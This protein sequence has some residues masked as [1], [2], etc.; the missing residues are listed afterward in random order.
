M[1]LREPG[2]PSARSRSSRSRDT[3]NRLAAIVS[4][5]S[6]AIIS[7]TLD[8]TVTSWNKGAEELF[9][10]RQEEMIGQ[11]IRCIIPQDRQ[12]EEEKIIEQIA[13]GERV[14]EY[15]TVRLHKHGRL[16]EVSISVSPIRGDKGS[17]IGAPKLRGR[18]RPRNRARH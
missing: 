4:S 18:S 6:D 2:S 1:R 8:G 17:I 14:E 7:K 15:G 11:S 16:I 9:G 5:S 3:V 10:Y 12:S 13:A